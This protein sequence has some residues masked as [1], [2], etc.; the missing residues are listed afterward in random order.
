[1]SS[2]PRPAPALLLAAGLSGLLVATLPTRVFALPAGGG[3]ST[4][5]TIGEALKPSSAEQIA[6]AD[7]LRQRGVIFYGAWWCPACFQQKNLFGKEAGNRLPYVECDKEETGR[8][9]CAAADVRVFPTW[10]LEG[11]RLEG[12]QTVEELKRWGGFPA[13]ALVSP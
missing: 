11:N 13:K 1:M 7:W 6:V 2:S 12:V 4:T 3:G 9:R 5:P 10:V 8:Q